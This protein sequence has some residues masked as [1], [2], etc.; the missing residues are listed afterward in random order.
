MTDVNVRS[1]SKQRAVQPVR[2]DIAVRGLILRT[3]NSLCG[4]R[5]EQFDYPSWRDNYMNCAHGLVHGEPLKALPKLDVA[6]AEQTVAAAAIALID[7]NSADQLEIIIALSERNRHELSA[8]PNAIWPRS[9]LIGRILDK[10]QWFGG[11]NKEG[12]RKVDRNKDF[13]NGPPVVGGEI[14]N[15]REQERV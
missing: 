4:W 12:S 13:V 5:I 14:V 8:V 7:R 11:A 2:H 3:G 6:R 1:Q 10:A 9:G 15:R